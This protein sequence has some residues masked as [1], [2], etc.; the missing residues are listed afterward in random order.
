MKLSDA[1]QPLPRSPEPDATLAFLREG[2]EFI[3]HRCEKLGTDAFTTRLMLRPVTCVRGAS[4]AA[5]FYKPGRMSRKGA[6]PRSVMTLLQDHGSVQT[7]DGEAHRQRRK[8][9]LDVMSPDRL[10]CARQFYA[11]EFRLASTASSE[12]V[13]R[14]DRF[15]GPVLCRTAFHW[16]G[17]PFSGEDVEK[18]TEEFQAMFTSAGSFGPKR[19]RAAWLRARSERWARELISAARAEPGAN[20]WLVDHLL[21]HRDASGTG[22]NDRDA[23]VELLNILRAIVAVGRYVGF[24]VHAMAMH[25]EA[26]LQLRAAPTEDM[27]RAF[28]DEVRRL[29]PFFPAIGGKVLQ[30]F[31][32][33]GHHFGKGDWV[34]LDLY[35]TCREEA[36]WGRATQFDPTRHLA[37]DEPAA[38]I[39]QGGGCMQAGHRCPGEA[40]TRALLTEAI[41]LMLEVDLAVPEQDMG[42]RPNEFPPLPRDGLLVRISGRHPG[43]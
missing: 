11:R 39:P 24:A 9:F 7:L 15:I 26:V 30:E 35:G 29:Y 18:R 40:L 17:M 14:F 12:R 20:G 13:V 10:R 19:V 37:P 36:S 2:Y 43:P 38:M 22:L 28:G 4:A 25:K 31:T 5:M 41:E 27:C 32:W 6:M 23:G 21:A 8:I 1:G 33:H 42:M 3:S 34:L 16:S